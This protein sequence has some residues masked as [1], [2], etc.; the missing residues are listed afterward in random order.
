MDTYNGLVNHPGHSR[1]AANTSGRLC[2]RRITEPNRYK[3][4]ARKWLDR[5]V[6]AHILSYLPEKGGEWKEHALILTLRVKGW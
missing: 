2:I 5:Y 6:I 3:N 4:A 1:K